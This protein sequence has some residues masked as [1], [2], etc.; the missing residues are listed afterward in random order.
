MRGE[1][2]GIHFGWI[3]EI[4]ETLLLDNGDVGLMYSSEADQLQQGGGREDCVLGLFSDLF[5]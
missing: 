1:A 5:G 2:P 3:G 4:S